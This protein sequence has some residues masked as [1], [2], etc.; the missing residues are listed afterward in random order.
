MEMFGEK[1]KIYEMTNKK[2][3]HQSL[4]SGINITDLKG[5][6]KTKKSAVEKGALDRTV[7]SLQVIKLILLLYKLVT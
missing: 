3:H 7:F 5:I 1:N 2:N 4:N 6:K